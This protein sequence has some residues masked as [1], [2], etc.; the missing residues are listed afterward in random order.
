M[1]RKLTLL[2]LTLGLLLTACAPSA[3]AAAAIKV[4]D[5]LSRE[6]KK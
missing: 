1:F 5:G 6:V 3:P 2:V 4:T